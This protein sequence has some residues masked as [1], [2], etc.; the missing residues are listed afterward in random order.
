VIEVRRADPFEEC[1]RLA[2]AHYENFPVASVLLPADRRPYLQAVYAFSR[3]ADDLADE[4]DASPR[5]RLARLDAWG[6]QLRACAAGASGA[7]APAG[8]GDAAGT[9]GALHPVFAA[10]SETI[11][12][13]GIPPD[14]LEALLSAFRQDVLTTRYETFDDLLDYCSR[15]AN[16]VG[17][18]VLMIFGHREPRLFQLSD[19]ICTALQLTNFWQDVSVDLKKGRVYLPLE[20]MR[21]HGVGVEDLAQPSA[22]EALR[23]LLKFQAERTKEYFLRGEPLLESVGKE[24]Q[25]ELRLVWFGGMTVLRKI[26]RRRYDVLASRPILN[27]RDRSVIFLRGLFMKSPARFDPLAPRRADKP[28]WDLT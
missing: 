4:G 26:A 19:A 11:R 9:G 1:A 27:G 25:L 22:G 10:L 5:E 15:S 2:D 6:E 28:R 14:L 13:N 18:I 16:P 17:R 23:N 12:R 21:R 20:D 7:G 3:V 24:L 8:T